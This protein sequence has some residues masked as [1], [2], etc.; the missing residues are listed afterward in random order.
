MTLLLGEDMTRFGA[1]QRGRNRTPA[2]AVATVAAG[3]WLKPV[4]TAV[5][6]LALSVCVM[7]HVQG[8]NGPAYWTWPW[9][10]LSP[11]RLFPAMLLC[12]VPFAVAQLLYHRQ[13]LGLLPSLALVALSTLLL[14]L[15]AIGMQGES[16]TLARIWRIVMNP[17]ATSYFT[18][19]ARLA[20]RD[21]ILRDYPSLVPG[22]NLH[23]Q[24]KPPGPVLL[25]VGAIRLLG[26]NE[27]AALLGG[28]MLGILAACAVP[29]VYLLFRAFTASEQSAFAG[30]SC[31]ALSPGLVL[32]LP[33][34]DQAY[35]IL[36]AGIL[37]CWVVA[38]RGN[39]I[40]YAVACGA[41]LCLATFLAYNLLVL[42]LFMAGY[43]V[44][45]LAADWSPRNMLA[46]GAHAG[47]ALL[48]VAAFYLV[49]WLAAAFNPVAAFGAAL[50]NQRTLLAHTSSP[51]PY[52]Q[53]IPF[54]LLDYAL[55]V[56]WIILLPAAWGTLAKLRR[57]RGE[58]SVLV[59]L[60]L[61]Q[62]LVV[63]LLGLLPG[64]TARVWVFMY[65]FMYF[66][67]ALELVQWSFPA[68]A[69]FYAALLLLLTVI[70]RNMVFIAI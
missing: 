37:G 30:A 45:R 16:F 42:G 19:A 61:A 6:A 58:Q 17:E 8:F 52:P 10:R 50:K 51:R 68:R 64:E 67:A 55:G 38:L 46:L 11:A 54:D 14:E 21:G 18:D 15:V 5:V 23:S 4:V 66:A 20:G 13:R 70:C 7:A 31:M 39:R 12:A 1:R 63:A 56:N 28:L 24:T 57:P 34:F 62:V 33:E 49:L 25:Y 36:T 32:F 53:T 60:G 29:A 26:P 48:T 59:L 2:N 40:V 44:W 43:L 9:R 41:F 3:R 47:A 22:F 65:P 69:A 27:S 35:P